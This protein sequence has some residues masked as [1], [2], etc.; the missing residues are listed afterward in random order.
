M[1]RVDADSVKV[2][3]SR[4][5]FEGQVVHASR[6]LQKIDSGF[7]KRLKEVVRQR[8]VQNEVFNLS[9]LREYASDEADELEEQG[10]AFF[11]FLSVVEILRQS[12]SDRVQSVLA[13]DIFL[14]EANLWNH[15]AGPTFCCEL[16]VNT[17][18]SDVA[19][20][21]CFSSR[22]VSWSDCVS[23]VTPLLVQPIDS[24]DYF[25][26]TLDRYSGVVQKSKGVE[27]Q[28]CTEQ[29]NG[30]KCSYFKE[31]AKSQN[32]I[33]NVGPVCFFLLGPHYSGRQTESQY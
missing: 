20:D 30:W 16:L 2:W 4:F 26:A 18:C 32:A 21:A 7:H 1:E 8:H 5:F 31:H 6:L 11:K 22:V 15:L 10:A 12:L 9:D 19:D 23:R 28:R 27:G 13:E 3:E 29:A 24:D 33:E 14:H 25:W 17:Q